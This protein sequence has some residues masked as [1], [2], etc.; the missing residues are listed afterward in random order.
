MKCLLLRYRMP[1]PLT[2]EQVQEIVETAG[3]TFVSER[4]G[5]K[6]LRS[7]GYAKK[8][9][10]LIKF[11]CGICD[12]VEE[13]GLD[14]YQRWGGHCKDCKK[15][16]K[17]IKQKI[18]NAEMQCSIESRSH[19]KVLGFD[20]NKILI[21]CGEH[22]FSRSWKALL[23]NQDCPE[24]IKNGNPKF[25]VR[26]AIK[27]TQGTLQTQIENQE[28]AELEIPDEYTLLDHTNDK[29][30][31]RCSENHIFR[32]NADDEIYCPYH[33]LTNLSTSQAKTH[34]EVK[35]ELFNKNAI[36]L[37][38]Y[39]NDKNL[40]ELK[41]RTCKSLFYKCYQ[42]FMRHNSI[43]TNCT[44]TQMDIDKKQL[45]LKRGLE[46]KILVESTMVDYKTWQ[47]DDDTTRYE[48]N[49]TKFNVICPRGHKLQT[50]QDD[51]V[52]GK[53]GCND[54]A[55]VSR[56]EK[57][58][59]PMDEVISICLNSGFELID[60]TYNGCK[61]I[62]NV[63]CLNCMKTMEIIFD[64]MRNG[65]C[66]NCNSSKSA[67]ALRV[68]R[69]LD[70]NLNVKTVRE[71]FS[72]G[73]EYQKKDDWFCCKDKNV[74]RYDFKVTLKNGVIMLIEFDGDQH[75]KKT[76]FFGGELGFVNRRNHDLLKSLYCEYNKIP[77]LRI[78]QRDFKNVRSII[79][80]HIDSVMNNRE[81]YL[82]YSNVQ[83]YISFKNEY[84]DYE[85]PDN[86]PKYKKLN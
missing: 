47:W 44:K 73:L 49:R 35:K 10:R 62:I 41:C 82:Y 65:K 59:L 27:N 43:C 7:G 26:F 19:Y 80:K 5:K 14:Q 40:L 69:V 79:N 83:D 57:G 33:N 2:L 67:G 9:E 38:T 1:P 75:F 21:N 22:Q 29:L 20:D 18:T 39:V 63:K 32:I 85:P 34:N 58:L 16:N 64:T 17:S 12:T 6:Q 55:N 60:E 72:F 53:R 77:L 70:S 46:F 52:N 23:V 15:S 25:T 54:C 61:N 36:L 86:L 3:D 30:L 13:I 8:D 45:L 24:C 71:E 66:P 76:D 28:D 4:R 51:F 56:S 42:N 78:A 84:I 31:L 68:K 11:K 50:C 37:S 48:H 81:C 74:L